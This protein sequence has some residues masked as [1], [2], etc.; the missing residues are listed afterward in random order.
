V[1]RSKL[2]ELEDP[3]IA[4]DVPKLMAANAEVQTA[5]KNLDVLYE[6]WAELEEKASSLTN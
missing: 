2:A 5:Q 4:S 6:R 3:T 1:L